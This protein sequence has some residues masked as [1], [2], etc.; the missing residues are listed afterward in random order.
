MLPVVLAPAVEALA[1]ALIN[2]AVKKLL[3]REDD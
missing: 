1:V 3:D 2:I